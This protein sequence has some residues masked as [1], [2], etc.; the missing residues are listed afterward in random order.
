MF[1]H[2]KENTK[3][4]HCPQCQR[5]IH[6]PG[7]LPGAPNGL[8]VVGDSDEMLAGRATLSYTLFVE[9][10][11]RVSTTPAWPPIEGHPQQSPGAVPQVGNEGQ[12]QDREAQGGTASASRDSG[13]VNNNIGP[14]RGRSDS[15]A[16]NNGGGSSS[17]K[18]AAKG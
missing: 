12:A 14:K 3:P 11:Q 9:H 15:P 4:E 1:I 17:G 5:G 13:G 18:R 6:P 7:A 16:N 2:P 8:A 10:A